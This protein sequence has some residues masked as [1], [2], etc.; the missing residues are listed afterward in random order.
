MVLPQGGI[1]HLS[2][3]FRVLQVQEESFFKYMF[4]GRGTAITCVTK[5]C[6]SNVHNARIDNRRP[7]LFFRNVFQLNLRGIN[8]LMEHARFCLK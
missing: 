8:V 1:R 4:L 7:L 3:A 2:K 5:E 6:T